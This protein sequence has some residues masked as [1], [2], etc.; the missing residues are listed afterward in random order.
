MKKEEP[1]VL[2][3]NQDVNAKAGPYTL[4]SV[5]MEG[6][7]KITDFLS[8]RAGKDIFKASATGK[9]D[10][11]TIAE[12][13]IRVNDS[14]GQSNYSFHFTLPDSAENEFY[15]LVVGKSEDGQPQ[16]PMVF[17]YVCDPDYFET[18][19]QSGFDP[20]A[21]VG[22]MSLYPF[23]QIFSDGSL[24]K[25]ICVE[26][27]QY[28]D[29]IPCI[30]TNVTNG[31]GG[32]GAGTSMGGAQFSSGFDSPTVA[33]YSIS[34]TVYHV[35]PDGRTFTYGSGSVCQH[36]G[37]CQVIYEMS[38]KANNK[39]TDRGCTKCPSA[40]G[41]V[42]AN[43]A[44]RTK[45]LVNGLRTKLALSTS[46]INFLLNN[47][48]LTE[49]IVAY[50]RQHTNAKAKQFAGWVVD[51]SML[52]NSPCGIGHDCVKSIKVMADGLRKFHGE[53]GQLIAQY[54]ESLI[55]DFDSF[56]KNDLQAFYDTAKAITEDY[57]NRMFD[58]VSGGFVAGVTPI[59]EIALFEVGAP[60][61]IKMLQRIPISWVYR[62]TRLNNMVK[63]VGLMGKM[64]YNNS[65]REF[66]TNAPVTKARE[67]FNSLTKHAI[68]KTTESNG[69]IKANMGNGNFITYRPITASSSNVPATLSLDFRAAG[70]WTQVRDVKFILP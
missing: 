40:P 41:G 29:P 56:T 32:G 64:G 9:D 30:R 45:L 5:D 26:H 63:K 4:N 27:D 59:L 18:F 50:L 12:E 68:S 17:H 36:P 20:T 2:E 19:E 55:S 28:G 54:F 62:G 44:S 6:I 31:S 24:S 13:V 34:I 15:N 10:G 42:A 57:N 65:T 61:T 1:L 51:F 14:L 21:F 70:I 25:D 39:A 66:A 52:P 7:P 37:E 35:T 47:R 60:V 69:L 46:E 67:L 3:T 48:R 8:S 49:D 38:T 11:P 53:G 58:S 16:E 33:S 22:T 23:D 43:M